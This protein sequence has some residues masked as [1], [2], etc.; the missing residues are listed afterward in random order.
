M[1]VNIRSEEP[2][3]E[4]AIRNVIFRA[5]Q[6]QSEPRLVD[7]LRDED[8]A[9]L[10]L[11]AEADGRIV[12]HI[13]FSPMTLD[14]ENP[15]CID[16]VFGL[17]PLSVL[18]EFQNSGIGTKLVQ[19]GLSLGIS[20]RWRLV[21][22]LGD[23]AYYSRFNFKQASKFNYYTEYDA[24]DKAFMVV[25]LDAYGLSVGPATIAKYHSIFSEVGI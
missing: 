19:R 6:S 1:K 9:E 3:D 2:G 20:K 18:P 4:D 10:S 21:F 12:G 7:R 5:F 24:P 8:A 16:R 14:P 22:V 11:V 15:S 23:P 25:S 13:L 17:A